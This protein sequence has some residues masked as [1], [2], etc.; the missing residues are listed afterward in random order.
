[1]LHWVCLLSLNIA[2]VP[3]NAKDNEW[4]WALYAICFVWRQWHRLLITH[5]PMNQ[6][7]FSS[8]QIQSCELN[9]SNH[10]WNIETLFFS[11]TD[12]RLDR[13]HLIWAWN[14]YILC[15][16]LWIYTFCSSF[17]P[18][19]AP[20]RQAFAFMCLACFIGVWANCTCG[21][22]WGLGFGSKQTCIEVHRAFMCGGLFVWTER[23]HRWRQRYLPLASR[24]FWL[25]R[26]IAA[27]Y[28]TI[29]M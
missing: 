27:P 22:C 13:K 15:C 3:N 20:F 19:L 11:G 1:M 18:T 26:K 4:V 16:E 8:V 23:W 6:M 28:I 9:D 14:V 25:N 2:R 29:Y 12:F 24:V 5:C 10:W 7:L 17:S 21:I